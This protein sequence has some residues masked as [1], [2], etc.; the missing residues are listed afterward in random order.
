MAPMATPEPAMTPPSATRHNRLRFAWMVWIVVSV[1]GAV[2]GAAVAWRLR[3]IDVSASASMVQAFQYSATVIAAIAWSGAQWIVLRRFGLDVYWWVPASVVATLVS[4]ILVIP[5]V[6][7]VFTPPLG[8]G[9]NPYVAM[10]SGAAA[11]AASGLVVGAAQALVVRTTV[12]NVAFAWVPVTVIGGAL[13][14]AV[15]EVW[16]AQLFGLPI[17]VLLGLLAAISSL[18]TALSQAPVLLR[19]LR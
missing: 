5:A 17:Y 16:S 9:I 8:V 10:L 19:F 15:T 12:G 11:L 2:I 7:R 13:G 6:L 3:A 14:G 1:I 18:L 4:A